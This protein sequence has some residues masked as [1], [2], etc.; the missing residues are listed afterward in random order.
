[1]FILSGGVVVGV[2]VGVSPVVVVCVT[3]ISNWVDTHHQ[4]GFDTLGILQRQLPRE[5]MRVELVTSQLQ[6][7]EQV[8]TFGWQVNSKVSPR[9]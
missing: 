6:P 7:T 1:M 2:A 8:I 3:R 9:T 4:Q 5:S